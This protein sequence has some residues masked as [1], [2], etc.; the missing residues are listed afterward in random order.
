MK[1][2]EEDDNITG[3]NNSGPQ[4]NTPLKH[5][6]A[7]SLIGD[8]IYNK[9]GEALGNIRDLMVSLTEGKIEYVVIEFGGFLGI[10]Q[11]YFAIP[12]N[13]L[14]IDSNHHHAFAIDETKE[15]LEKY[16]G[17]DKDHWPQTN[18]HSEN[19]SRSNYGGFMGG[20]TGSEY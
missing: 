14:S 2:I 7:S 15:S 17:F 3:V 11:K 16:P 13:A 9:Q 5:L 6:T 18:A 19:S 8:K 10:N 20:N 4:A 1:T 12:F